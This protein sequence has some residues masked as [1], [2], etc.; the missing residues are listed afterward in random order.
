MFGSILNMSKNDIKATL[1]LVGIGFFV[2][3]LIASWNKR[4]VSGQ[5]GIPGQP[6]F[7]PTP[8]IPQVNAPYIV[9]TPQQGNEYGSVSQQQATESGSSSAVGF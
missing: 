3:F 1:T 5:A 9:N 4:S 8:Q 6:R 7:V 2:G